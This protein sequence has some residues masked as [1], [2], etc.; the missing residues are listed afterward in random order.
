MQK[1]PEFEQ[2]FANLTPKYQMRIIQIN[3]T[4]IFEL[5]LSNA[6]LALYETN[7]DDKITKGHVLK[8]VKP[9]QDQS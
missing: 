3:I 4:T 6:D 8:R 5:Q 2:L 7:P 1:R 9:Q